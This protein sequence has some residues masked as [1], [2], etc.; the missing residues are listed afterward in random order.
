MC[1]SI[2][3]RLNIQKERKSDNSNKEKVRKVGKERRMEK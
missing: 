1:Q 3:A 2:K